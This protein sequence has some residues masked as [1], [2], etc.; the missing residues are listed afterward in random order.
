MAIRLDKFLA[1]TY[2]KYSRNK[3]NQFILSGYVLVNNKVQTKPSYLVN[4][5]DKVDLKVCTDDVWVSRGAYKLLKALEEYKIDLTDK[6]CLDIGCS[7]GGFTHVMLRNNAKKV[8]AVDVGT[9]QFDKSILND[10]V[11]LMEQTH[12]CHTNVLDFEHIDFIACDVSFISAKKII[13]HVVKLF[14]YPFTFVCLIK[15]QFELTKEILD[16]CKGVIPEK[17]HQQ[18][19]SSVCNYAKQLGLEVSNVIASPIQGAKSNNTEFLV[20]FRRR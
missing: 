4:D 10:K 19:I 8:Y 6:V 9:N 1:K 7:T 17:Y 12:F 11:V 3:L 15:P 13:E 5:N 18:A 14:N 20:C 2:S 16:K